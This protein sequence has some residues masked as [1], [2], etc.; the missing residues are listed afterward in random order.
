M[1]IDTVPFESLAALKAE[2]GRLLRASSGSSQS[3]DEQANLPDAIVTLLAKARATGTRLD[4][5]VDREAAQSIL[6]YWTA[7]L[8]TLPS[9]VS[10]ASSLPS[11][12]Q[13]VAPG[14]VNLQLAEF[15]AKTV[16]QTADKAEQAFG[17]FSSTEKALAQRILMRLL[18]LPPGLHAF[19]PNRVAR[20]DLMGLRPSESAARVLDVLNATGVFRESDGGVELRYEALGRV[21]PRF[22]GWLEKRKAFREAVQYWVRHKGE[23][24]EK[25]AL[26]SGDLLREV[27]KY[28]DLSSYE[29]LYIDASRRLENDRARND[30]IW[31]WV[32]AG[33]AAT[34]LIGWAIAV[35]QLRRANEQTR[36]AKQQ[37]VLA[38]QEKTNAERATAIAVAAAN[39]AEQRGKELTQAN[40]G[41]VKKQAFSAL[42][43]MARAL[44]EISVR[45]EP[46]A[47]RIARERLQQMITAYQGNAELGPILQK[48]AGLKTIAE[49]KEATPDERRTAQYAIMTQGRQLRKVALQAAPQEV[50][51]MLRAERKA[52]FG[53]AEYCTKEIVSIY[54]KQ[55]YKEADAFVAEFW[56][57]YWGDLAFVEG[58]EVEKAMVQ[59]GRKL[60]E[61]DKKFQAQA[62]ADLKKRAASAKEKALTPR[63]QNQIIQQTID[64][65]RNKLT[66]ADHA[67]MVGSDDVAALRKLLNAL[68]AALTKELS[69]PV[70]FKPPVMG[71]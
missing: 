5:A 50:T 70:D 31:K 21:W 33:L 48:I 58:P 2:H 61:I 67:K 23:S 18:R 69:Q 19:M 24:G 51:E 53:M 63:Q 1:A 56:L 71:Y 52:A 32:F 65:P 68:E 17:G 43:P 6:D 16:Q 45:S 57:L 60:Q 49:G 25:A 3:V 46:Q 4:T 37:T 66:S 36:I 41:L 59:F 30:R 44:T 47:R 34:A 8:F 38:E 29:E 54:S 64:D 39:L 40:S 42:I 26:L 14:A 10:A 11:L 62:P 7:K 12:I 9:G 35:F 22:A 28:H 15:D 27:E 55:P 13:G 20:E